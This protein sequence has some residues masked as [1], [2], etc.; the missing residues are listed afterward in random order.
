MQLTNIKL[1]ISTT[2]NPVYFQLGLVVDEKLKAEAGLSHTGMAFAVVNKDE[3][4]ALMD[5]GFR[6]FSR[7]TVDAD[8]REEPNEDP[9]RPSLLKFEL[10]S[11]EF[12]G[13]AGEWKCILEAI[14][15]AKEETPSP[16][17]F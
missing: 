5:L 14:R 16:K 12:T 7:A 13:G 1:S 3:L 4:L 17:P 15:K 10:N 11:A 2:K 6:P 8:F 9:K